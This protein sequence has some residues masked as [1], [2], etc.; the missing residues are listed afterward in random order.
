M[1]IGND[2]IADDQ[3]PG[4][5]Q[6]KSSLSFG[7]VSISSNGQE[8]GRMLSNSMGALQSTFNFFHQNAYGFVLA[9]VAIGSA[10]QSI[11]HQIDISPMRSKHD[12][13]QVW[14]RLL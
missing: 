8:E 10:S 9:Q 4:V 6:C 13:G 12:H 14:V 2:S 7:S 11:G 3:A 5:G 1:A